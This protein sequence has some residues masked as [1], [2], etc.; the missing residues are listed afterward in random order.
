M[1]MTGEKA[2]IGAL[3]IIERRRGGWIFRQPRSGKERSG[4]SLIE[5]NPKDERSKD[6]RRYFP[7]VCICWISLRLGQVSAISLPRGFSWILWEEG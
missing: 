7:M 6:V 1:L 3:A 5:E 4:V 2:Q